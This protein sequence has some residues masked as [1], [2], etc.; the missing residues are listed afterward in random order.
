MPHDYDMVIGA[1]A[2]DDTA[3]CPNVVIVIPSGSLAEE[4]A[5]ENKLTVQNP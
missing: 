5:L 1:T 2:D 4:V 3:S